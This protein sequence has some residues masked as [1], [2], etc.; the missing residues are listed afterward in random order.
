MHFCKWSLQ[1]IIFDSEGLYHIIFCIYA[2]EC[3]IETITKQVILKLNKRD[4]EINY[5]YI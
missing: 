5:L 2:Y 1:S 4:Y 3:P